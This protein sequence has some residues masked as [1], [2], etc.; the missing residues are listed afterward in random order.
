MSDGLDICRNVRSHEATAHIPII[1][2]TARAEESERI[3]GLDLGA[4]DYMA[5]PFS[6]NELVA[7]VRALLRRA[8]R[9][10]PITGTITYGGIAGRQRTATSCRRTAVR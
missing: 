3:V 7:R 10:T 2:L 4:D 9:Q 5:K 6:P 1:M 8:T